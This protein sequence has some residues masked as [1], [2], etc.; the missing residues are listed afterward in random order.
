GSHGDAEVSERGVGGRLAARR[1]LSLGGVGR[2]FAE[3]DLQLLFL[4][5]AP[6]GD[7]DLLARGEAADGAG[8]F[9]RVGDVAAVDGG[10]DVTRLDAG[11]KARA[12][13]LRFGHQRALRL[14]E[15]NRLGNLFRHLLDLDAKPAA[16]YRAVL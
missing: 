16:G 1:H 9:S 11:G 4:A 3:L 14:L 10:D 12:I 13:R 2:Q 5:A 15:A 8:K 7:L 6:Q